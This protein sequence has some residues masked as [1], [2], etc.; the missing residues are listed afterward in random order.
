MPKSPDN[1]GLF[2]QIYGGGGG[3][4]QISTHKVMQC[5]DQKELQYSVHFDEKYAEMV[6]YKVERSAI[7]FKQNT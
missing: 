4:C 1:I 7:I 3:S 5:S 6:L 2:G